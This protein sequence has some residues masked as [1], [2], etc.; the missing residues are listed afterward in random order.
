MA[1]N[2]SQEVASTLSDVPF[3][4]SAPIVVELAETLAF[5]AA[6]RAPPD[7]H[8]FI[9][10][11]QRVEHEWQ[12]QYNLL[13]AL[14]KVT[15]SINVSDIDPLSKWVQRQNFEYTV[16]LNVLEGRHV[17]RR[18][19]PS[20]NETKIR[21]LRDLGFVFVKGSAEGGGNKRELAWNA[22]ADLLRKYRD[23]HGH[24]HV[25][26]DQR[27]EDDQEREEFKGLGPWVCAM[28]IK[29]RAYGTKDADPYLTAVRMQRLLDIGVTLAPRSGAYK[30]KL[31]LETNYEKQTSK[32]PKLDAN[33]ERSF[34]ALQQFSDKHGHTV[35]PLKPEYK[36]LRNW[37]GTQKSE[38]KNVQK[39]EPTTLTAY[40]LQRLADVGFSI[41]TRKQVTYE[42]HLQHW[43]D[44]R[45][46]YG[47]DP[48][49]KV[50]KGD[51]A[52]LANWISRLRENYRDK[53]R[54]L[55]TNLT[56]ERVDQLTQLG[57]VWCAI[58]DPEKAAVRKPWAARF[59]ELKQYV[60]NHGHAMVPRSFP[61]LGEWVH[62]MRREHKAFTGGQKSSMTQEKV[63]KMSSIGFVW[64]AHNRSAFAKHAYPTNDDDDSSDEEVLRVEDD[65]PFDEEAGCT[66]EDQSSD[67]EVEGVEK[68]QI[69][70]SSHRN[71]YA[72]QQNSHIPDHAAHA[73]HHRGFRL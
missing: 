2:E 5:P 61:E 45:K 59:A 71:E 26:Q 11:D 69:Y 34:A 37:M 58:K 60:E 17:P 22:K 56:Q 52:V 53:N 55:K 44:Y 16:F 38:Y 73:Q 27:L 24:T 63:D 19:I 18:R 35:V 33:W 51:D 66:E 12:Q 29:M 42:E 72:H 50:E 40:K 32:R 31:L 67:E 7:P 30:R 62:R 54:G 46:K 3:L 41:Q 4:S 15:K 49:R 57:F 68:D 10:T 36:K 6:S 13:V 21:M 14:K 43:L 39:G 28:R 65:H 48:L 1:T 23:K 70:P 20:M 9:R 8:L 25:P 64:V 47:R